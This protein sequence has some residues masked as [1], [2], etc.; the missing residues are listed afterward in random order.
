[1]DHSISINS[2][3]NCPECGQPFDDEIWLIV[4]IKERP[5]LLQ[6]LFNNGLHEVTCPN[7][8]TNGIDVPL[9]L[10]RPVADQP[11]LFS[12][13]EF[14]PVEQRA[15]HAVRLAMMLRDRMGTSWRDEW[16]PEGMLLVPRAQLSFSREGNVNSIANQLQLESEQGQEIDRA[17][18]LLKAA[19][20]DINSPAE[21]S[22]ALAERPDIVASLVASLAEYD[23]SSESGA[24]EKYEL[25][26]HAVNA[27]MQDFYS[28]NNIQALDAAIKGWD[29][30]LNDVS[31]VT[32]GDRFK[33]VTLSDAGNGYYHRYEYSGHVSDLDRALRLWNDALALTAPDSPERLTIQGNLGAGLNAR[34]RRSSNSADLS[35]AI[36]L[37]EDVI[38]RSPDEPP[39]RAPSLNNLAIALHDLYEQSGIIG[40]LTRAIE[41]WEEAVT[42]TPKETADWAMYLSNLS[43]GLRDRYR[44][45]KRLLDL[46]AAIESITDS[47]AA[48]PEDSL[49]RA[50]SLSNLGTVLIARYRHTGDI[51]DLDASIEAYEKAVAVIPPSAPDWAL[52]QS[53]LGSGLHE[54]Y[55]RLGRLED[56]EGAIGAYR[57]TV[58]LT[59]PNSLTWARLQ[60]F[61]GLGLLDRYKHVGSIADLSASIDA[62]K[63]AAE[64]A[65]HAGS[66]QLDRSGYLNNLGN[67]FRARYRHTQHI[68]D[69]GQAIESYESAIQLISPNASDWPLIQS[70]L[71]TALHD[72]YQLT[73]ELS[74]LDASVQAYKDA[75][76]QTPRGSVGW[77]PRANNLG[78]GLHE[79]YRQAQDMESLT[80]AIKVYGDAAEAA[81]LHA[82]DSASFHLNLGSAL[83]DMYESTGAPED[84]QQAYLAYRKASEHASIVAPATSLA[85]AKS[86][87]RLALKI[88]DWDTVLEAAQMGREAFSRLYQANTLRSEG[89][90]W[91]TEL[92]GLGVI[93]AYAEASLDRPEAAALALENSLAQQL[94]LALGRGRDRLLLEL[95]ES[96]RPDIY[97]KYARLSD[98]LH[99]L[100]EL[101]KGGKVDSDDQIDH[102]ELRA[103]A[104]TAHSEINDVL[105][106]IRAL[107]GFE[108][109]FGKP[110]FSDVRM[111]VRERHPL[112]YLATTE[113]GSVVVLVGN[114]GTEVFHAEMTLDDLTEMMLGKRKDNGNEG[115]LYGQIVGSPLLAV[116]LSEA[117]PRIGKQLLQPLV[118]RLIALD[119]KKI[120]LIPSGRLN[121]LPLHAATILGRDGRAL[122][123]MDEFT[124]SY[125]PSSQVLAECQAIAA[126][127]ASQSPTALVVGNP[128]PLPPGT[129]SLKYARI[130]AEL[131]AALFGS[132]ATTLTEEKAARDAILAH[133]QEKTFLHFACHGFF[134][135]R[136]PSESGL[137]L[138]G[139]QM[140]ILSLSEVRDK[141]SLRFSRLVVLSA[142][143]T[144]LTD[145]RRLPDEVIGL[146]T[147]FMQAGAPGVV[148]S[149][150]P[151][152]DRSTALLMERFYRNMIEDS[153]EPAS[154]LRDAQRWLRRASRRELGDY[155]LSH[156]VPRRMNAED[157]YEAHK[158]MMED[159]EPDA[160]AFDSPYYWAS[161]TFTGA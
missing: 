69:L 59:H 55:N 134:N 89:E 113:V 139:E 101:A 141:L 21:V 81:P 151:V 32:T 94:S 102:S 44:E 48:T 97:K 50:S 1:M 157:A 132:Q 82:P 83:Q 143:Q 92:Q 154:A 153:M 146:P 142:C 65:E 3:L 161:F 46:D 27:A 135:L 11:L 9:L 156:I 152:D 115:L 34:Y 53:N 86:W 54:R 29:R 114:E 100:E 144:G 88:G 137:I 60:N 84:L 70:N 38:A 93:E 49:N 26:L 136:A 148:A 104:T 119:V 87:S 4:D 40:H 98:R 127:I 123:F 22:Q 19:G 2:T 108:Q 91:R 64:A 145:F 72:R 105:N 12:P 66:D 16:L 41:L 13:A 78:T 138:S 160:P 25:V 147:G 158:K 133:L 107:P 99:N 125:A 150:W 71:G 45:T 90:T 15:E 56:L 112:A 43:G 6:R 149:L 126:Q 37:M 63:S 159:G 95:L 128:Q 76:A 121:F 35:E 129:N 109:L 20:V 8:H 80:Q 30:I 74:D 96:E 117:L 77:A 118:D 130:E 33:V 75:L 85:V 68:E 51:D 110:T 155:Y 122:S 140:D 73:R 42:L 7:G 17:R 5:D 62:H 18:E 23:G 124:I 67:G 79:R 39:Q 14:A 61:L 36:R 131:V 52:A 28:G 31:F 103:Q 24:Q 116:A 58:A 106:E 47:M 111:A 120:T 10:L 57:A